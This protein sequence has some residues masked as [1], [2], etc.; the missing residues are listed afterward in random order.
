MSG[1]APKPVPASRGP[2]PSLQAHLP[3]DWWRTLFTATYLKTDGDVVEND[4][5]TRNEV[6]FLLAATGLKPGDKLLDLCCGQGRHTIELAR[7]GYRELTGIDRSRYLIRLARKRAAAVGARIRFC[8]G[9]ARRIRVDRGSLDGVFVMGNSFGYCDREQE[10]MD[11]LLAIHR[12]LKAGGIVALDLTD[13]AWLR[14]NF[15]TRSWE[16]IGKSELVARERELGT[17]GNRL[18]CRE[19]I[20]SAEKGVVRDQFYAERLYTVG[21]IEDLL[22][23]AGFEKVVHHGEQQCGSD[24]NQ[25]LGMMANRMFITA[26]SV[27]AGRRQKQRAL[28]VSVILGD[29]TLPD[30][31][32][33]DQRFNPEDADALDRLKAALAEI[34]GYEFAFLE[35][36][37]SLLE[38]LQNRPPGLVLNFC[39]EGFRNF[40]TMELHVPALLEMLG[41]PYTGSGPACLAACYDKRL[42]HQLAAGLAIPTPWELIC[43]PG[44]AVDWDQVPLPALVKPNFGDG[45]FGINAGSLARSGP[46]VAASAARLVRQCPG[47]PF[48]IQEFL[49][50][51]EYTVTL[52]GN[53]GM[54]LASLPI[55]EADFSRLP[56]DH[57]PIL[58]YESKF[59]PDSPYWSDIIFRPA[60]LDGA[61]RDQLERS[62]R[63]L[64]E[65]LQ[66]RDYARFDFRRGSDGVIRLLEVNP[67]PGWCW[68]GKM[69]LAANAAG[70]SYPA[71]LRRLLETAR[72]RISAHSQRQPQASTL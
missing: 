16:W 9:D 47:Q 3:K 18:V 19:I 13:G 32:K 2:L 6:D 24:R 66:C 70:L 23:Q 36:H 55:I 53:P 60:Q 58:G 67:N 69:N 28:A 61:E 5:N 27:P 51:A 33:R 15:Q 34:D 8:E 71:L 50:G 48:L 12:S 52:L 72:A 41:L 45:G 21:R 64:F 43:P 29:S 30:P 25:D 31:V 59:L 14:E 62:A 1:E 49:P 37:A 26:R 57:P 54:G 35:R 63:E 56:A 7:R 46:E 44:G 17:N 39:D 4:E 42:V 38:N 22:H 20:V 40:P 65:R 11:V 10:D 68:D